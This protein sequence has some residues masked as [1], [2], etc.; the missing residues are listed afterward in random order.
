MALSAV[1]LLDALWVALSAFL[2]LVALALVYFLVR[3]ARTVG[4]V[5]SLLGGLE[6]DGLPVV[7]RMEETVERVN[8][9]LD[10]VDRVTDSA[11]DAVESVDGAVRGVTGA[12]AHPVQKISAL[13]AAVAH[14]AAALRARRDARAALEAGR[15]AAV[16]RE[17]EI[18]EELERSRAE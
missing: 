6:A 18:Q 15:E 4:Q 14:G 17:Q 10:K 7:R 8:T 5:G 16:R 12:V 11:V 1:T 9:Q 13:S 2:V 3:L